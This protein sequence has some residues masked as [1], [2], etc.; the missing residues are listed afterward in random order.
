MNTPVRILGID[1]GLRD[2]RLRG[3]RQGRPEARLCHQRLH[4]EQRQGQPARAHQ[5][6]ARRHRRSHRAAPAAA[7][8]GG[9]GVRERQSAI[10]AAARPGARR[11]DLGAGRRRPA[12]GGIHGLAGQAG[13]GRPWQGGQ[14]TGATDG[15]A[16]AATARSRLPPTRPMRW[17]A[18]S[19]TPMADRGWA[20]SRRAVSA[21]GKDGWCDW[22]NYRNA[23][24]EE[25]AADHRRCRR[26]RLRTRSADEHLLQ[27]AGT[28]RESVAGHASRRARGRA[29]PLRLRRRRRTH[30][31]PPVDQDFR[32]RRA[33]GAGAALRPVGE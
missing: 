15:D 31:L 24:R 1:P 11:G 23:D 14:G 8:G 16:P 27:P 30:R 3:N 7:G 28:G 33:H 20:I 12:G 21:S 22:K 25:S 5:D 17:P 13:G 19:A 32:H 9:E 29:H 26:H 10:D 4:Q 2:H 18:P 6:A